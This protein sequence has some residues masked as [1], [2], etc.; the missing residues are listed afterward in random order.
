MISGPDS[1]LIGSRVNP[2]FVESRFSLPLVEAKTG[3]DL[4]LTDGQVVQALVQ[5]RGDQLGLLLRGRLLDVA[6]PPDAQPGQSLSFRVQANPNGSL[7]LVPTPNPVAGAAAAAEAQPVISRVENLLFH[8][9]GAPDSLAMFKPGVID[10]MLGTLARSD[11]QAQWNAMRPLMASLSPEAIRLALVGA[12]GSESA[13]ARGRAAPTNDPKQ[14][15]R[16]LLLALGQAGPAASEQ[17]RDT[18]VQ[19]QG[20]LDEVEAAQVQAVQAQSQAAMLF[21]MVLPFRD[22]DPVAL[23]FE[24]KPAGQGQPEV[25]TVNVHS[26]NSELGELWLKTEVH[27]KSVLELVMWATQ[28]GVVEQ[29]EQGAGA[30]AAGLQQAGLTLRSFQVI[31]GPRPA[32]EPQARPSDSGMILDL[33]A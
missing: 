1:G 11:L 33:R 12:L 32:P 10:G 15:L 25:L 3:R 18:R 14:L 26:H 9:G 5:A 4:G 24:R 6:V 19:L 30:L 2:L 21:G 20:A 27:G 7:T 13:L 16:Q 23:E 17:D 8:P 22:A 28:P 29:A 31:H